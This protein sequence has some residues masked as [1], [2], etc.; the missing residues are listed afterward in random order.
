MAVRKKTEEQHWEVVQDATC[1]SKGP[2]EVAPQQELNYDEWYKHHANVLTERLDNVKEKLKKLDEAMIDKA[3]L[4]L[5]AAGD[6]CGD[7]RIKQIEKAI[8]IYR[9]VKSC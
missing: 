5:V 2:T 7:L 9:E 6:G 8:E 1:D 3:L 4:L